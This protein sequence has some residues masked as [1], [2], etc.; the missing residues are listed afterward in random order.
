MQYFD[1]LSVDCNSKPFWKACKPYLSN[2]NSN[3]QKNVMLLEKDK[4][5]S[6]QKDVASTFNKHFESITDLLNLFSWPGHTSVSSRNDTIGSIIEKVVFHP[7]IKAIKKKFKIKSESSFNLLFAET[8]KGVINDL[9]IKK[10]SS[11][12]IPTCLF[13][14]C[15]KM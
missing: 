8:K 3:I 1:K 12:K 2:K 6:K 14:K 7:S 9:N 5:L 4:L 15:D 13:K 11:S 10:A